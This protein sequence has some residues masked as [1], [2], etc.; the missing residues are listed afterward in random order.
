MV[1]D[2]T[3]SPDPV[4]RFPFL[5][6]DLLVAEVFKPPMRLSPGFIPGGRRNTITTDSLKSSATLV[7]SQGMICKKAGNYESNT[8]HCI[9]FDLLT[10]FCV[11]F[12]LRE[13]NDYV[14]F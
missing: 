3:L 7:A 10:F 12:F 1:D 2:R 6:S 9:S 11:R 8:G 4:S 13:W 5:T 14:W